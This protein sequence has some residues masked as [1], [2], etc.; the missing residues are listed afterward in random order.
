MATLNRPVALMLASLLTCAA[1][2]GCDSE[3]SD[4]CGDGPTTGNSAAPPSFPIELGRNEGVFRFY[5]ETR[6]AK[7]RVQVFYDGVQ[8]FDSGCVG[9]TGDK[10]LTYGPGNATRVEV[11]LTP[12]C[13]GT[14]MTSWLFEVGCPTPSARLTDGAPAVVTGQPPQGPR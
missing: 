2:S 3:G 7:D 10:M 13:A 5:Y 6:S 9:E 1:L 8:L 4:V 12:N 11:V 14:P